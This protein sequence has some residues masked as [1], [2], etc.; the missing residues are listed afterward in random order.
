[1]EGRLGVVHTYSPTA[2]T[3]KGFVTQAD[4]SFTDKKG[5]TW[6]GSMNY[7]TYGFYFKGGNLEAKQATLD[8]STSNTFTMPKDQAYDFIKELLG[9]KNTEK[10]TWTWSAPGST[11][12]QQ[13][14]GEKK[15]DAFTTGDVSDKADVKITINADGSNEIE[16]NNINFKESDFVKKDR[17]KPTSS[18]TTY[19]VTQNSSPATYDKRN[20]ANINDVYYGGSDC[21]YT[22]AIKSSRQVQ[23]G[24]GSYTTTEYVYDEDGNAV[25]DDDGNRVTQQVTHT[26]PIY[27]TE[28][29]IEKVTYSKSGDGWDWSETGT[30]TDKKYEETL[31]P[32]GVEVADQAPIGSRDSYQGNSRVYAASSNKAIG[33]SLGKTVAKAVKAVV[34]SG[35]D[36][37]TAASA[38][39]QPG[40]DNPSQA[41]A[42]KAEAKTTA[43]KT[44]DEDDK[45]A[46][47]TQVSG[48]DKTD[49]EKAFA[50]IKSVKDIAAFI[51]QVSKLLGRKAISQALEGA[52][53]TD[54]LKRLIGLFKEIFGPQY[55]NSL[56]GKLV[57][58]TVDNQAV[59]DE[60]KVA[61]SDQQDTLPNEIKLAAKMALELQEA[62]E[63]KKDEKGQVVEAVDKTGAK[64]HY[65]YE[66]SGLTEK[67]E[68]A[69]GQV[70]VLHYNNQGQLLSENVAGRTR[71]YTYQ[72]DKQG[73]VAK[74]TMN[75]RSRNGSQTV[76]YDVQG[77]VL[78][79]ERDD[80]KSVYHYS[81][82]S[83]DTFQV[84]HY[85]QAGNIAEKC[86][87]KNNRMVK[88]EKADGSTSEYDYLTDSNNKVVAITQKNTDRDGAET[89]LK[90]DGTGKLVSALGKDANRYKKTA[91]E[92]D[93][94]QK[95]MFFELTKELF[96]D[97][98]MDGTR[99]DNKV[100]LKGVDI[101]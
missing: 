91:Q 16:L 77:R 96:G 97:P 64:H 8:G 50:K 38:M 39:V 32:T 1:M 11:A 27:S 67:V 29:T 9:E 35:E 68:G 4:E 22:T 98:R 66:A 54:I 25:V 26:Y 57:A 74:I 19:T 58:V 7:D 76:D 12:T 43:T 20:M 33:I 34:N 47:K 55:H 44:V 45:V 17:Y 100:L 92:D 2:K 72:A 94:S 86:S 63:I 85:N 15:Q 48:K 49:L 95:T 21:G 93:I 36:V 6:T 79:I 73:Q 10:E 53:N 81:D 70:S 60:L 5:V 75:E 101:E 42:G 28:W 62:K 99:L 41:T 89:T 46:D 30:K 31:N 61:M 82:A 13:T 69:G 3:A 40:K 56:V 24:T 83:S 87:Y 37:V 80:Q 65:N 52:S 88:K 71:T 51:D 90:Y 78:K 18:S 84:T 23:V 14:L 59:L